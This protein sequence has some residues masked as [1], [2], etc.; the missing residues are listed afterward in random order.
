MTYNFSRYIEIVGSLKVDI[1]PSH[2]FLLL[3]RGHKYWRRGIGDCGVMLSYEVYIVDVAPF[4]WQ[5]EGVTDLELV[6]NFYWGVAG[7]VAVVSEIGQ[8]F[9]EEQSLHNSKF[10]KNILEVVLLKFLIDL[11]SVPDGIDID[12][13]YRFM[14]EN[15]LND[16]KI[17]RLSEFIGKSHSED[18]IPEKDVYF[19][20]VSHIVGYFF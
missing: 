1:V 18:M 6:E 3:D 9:I 5:P 12:L 11:A 7:Y 20:L 13:D 14:E 16:D 15:V 4:D 17:Y 2:T 10:T 19:L 8:I